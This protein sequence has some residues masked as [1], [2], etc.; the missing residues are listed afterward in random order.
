MIYDH[1]MKLIAPGKVVKD[2]I[3]NQIHTDP[4]ETPILCG[5]K[6]VGRSEFYNAA[7]AGLRPE[8]VFVIH[9]Y[10]Y[11]DERLVEFEGKR[12]NVIRTYE[13]SF[14]ELELTCERVA[15]NG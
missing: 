15:A 5:L 4:I 9:A 6:S 3:G 8:L 11:N 1:E 7:T 14:E 2:E 10:E 13:T 12:Y